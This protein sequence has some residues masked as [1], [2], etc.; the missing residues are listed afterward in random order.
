MII[1]NGLVTDPANGIEKITNII[2]KNG[3]I[4]E[5]TDSCDFDDEEI[6]DALQMMEMI[7][8]PIAFL[9]LLY[10]EVPYL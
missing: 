2:I 1:K 8:L 9:I 3:K 5:M 4:A 10:V 7:V 6:I